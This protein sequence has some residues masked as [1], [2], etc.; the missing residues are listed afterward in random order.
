MYKMNK[1][2]GDSDAQFSADSNE[3]LKFVEDGDKPLHAGCTKWTKLNVIVQTFN[4]K[5]K[6]RNE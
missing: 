1:S 4:L 6:A 2:N 3:F 5:A